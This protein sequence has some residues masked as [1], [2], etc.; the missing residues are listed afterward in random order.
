MSSWE[1]LQ[2]EFTEY[3]LAGDEE[4]AIKLAQEALATGSTPVE[5]FENCIAPALQ[6]V[7]KR[8]ETL[9]I[10]LPEMVTAADSVDAVNAKV[11]NPAV[12]DSQDGASMSLGKVLLATV[13]GDLH[14]IGK[15]MVGLMMKVNGFEVIDLGTNVSPSDIVARAEQEEV[16][17]IGMSAL[18]TTCLPY[19]K[20]VG[21]HLVGKDIRNKYAV[22]IGGAAATPEIV[23]DMGANAYGSSAADGVKKCKMLLGKL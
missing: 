11:I 13:Q 10:F 1:T 2:P 6:D 15:N 19:M 7:G 16:D 5:F 22:I 14:D 3:M 8:F 17:I 18:L 23:E 21:D 12:A 9:D 20:D 4:S